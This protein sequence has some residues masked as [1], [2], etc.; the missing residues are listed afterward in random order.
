MVLIL[1]LEGGREEVERCGHKHYTSEYTEYTL[2]NTG[3]IILLNYKHHSHLHQHIS[4]LNA[5]IILQ[6]QNGNM[7]T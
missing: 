7:K 2:Q 1:W 4:Q 3:A 5:R 6:W